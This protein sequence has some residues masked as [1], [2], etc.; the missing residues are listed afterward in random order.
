[1]VLTAWGGEIRNNII[2]VIPFTAFLSLTLYRVLSISLHITFYWGGTD[3][4][5]GSVCLQ[6]CTCRHLL[7]CVLHSQLTIFTCAVQDMNLCSNFPNLSSWTHFL[8]IWCQWTVCVRFIILKVRPCWKERKSF[9]SLY[10]Y[11]LFFIPN[12]VWY[13]SIM[14]FLCCHLMLPAELGT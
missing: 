13:T 7:M 11:C 8:S 4:P 2:Q 9:K 5:V 1:M 14:F 10:F 6:V 12:A 3:E